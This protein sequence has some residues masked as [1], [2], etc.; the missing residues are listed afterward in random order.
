MSEKKEA[1]IAALES[2]VAQGQLGLAV[3]AAPLAIVATQITT[4]L[5][6]DSPIFKVLVTVIIA[7]FLLS[8]GASLIFLTAC[9]YLIIKEKLCLHGDP[10]DGAKLLGYTET[11]LLR[12]KYTI[13]EDFLLA[14]IT[15]FARPAY[16]L[17]APGF[18]ALGVTLIIAVWL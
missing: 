2:L 17:L 11:T 12:K 6:I 18:L 4:L 10:Q 15:R 9:R 14:T 7:I 1:Y 13:N 8:C 5:E 16:L 3:S